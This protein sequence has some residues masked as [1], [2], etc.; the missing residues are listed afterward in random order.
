MGFRSAAT[1]PQALDLNGLLERLRA[2]P[3]R[4]LESEAA[5]KM[6]AR[7]KEVQSRLAA[8]S[9]SE[10]EATAKILL[11]SH[12]PSP[13][14]D[15]HFAAAYALDE[16]E[17]GICE[18]N[19][20]YFS[21][22]ALASLVAD[23]S[24]EEMLSSLTM[25]EWHVKHEVLVRRAWMHAHHKLITKNIRLELPFGCIVAA[26]GRDE[27]KDDKEF[28]TLIPFLHGLRAVTGK[29]LLLIEKC[30]RP[31]FR[32]TDASGV[33]FG[34][35]VS[36]VP[37]TKEGGDEQD[38]EEEVVNCLSI[39]EHEGIRVVI[40]EPP[41]WQ[42]IE[43]DMETLARWRDTE[44]L[45]A[46]HSGTRMSVCYPPGFC[47][48]VEPCSPAY[49]V[50]SSFKGGQEIE[51]NELAFGDSLYE[52]VRKKLWK[53]D[54]KAKLEPRVKPCYLALYA[55]APIRD[56]TRA[57]GRFQERFDLGLFLRGVADERRNGAA[58]HR[59]EQ[60]EPLS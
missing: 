49:T 52:S 19:D 25:Q 24:R 57:R 3:E 4:S 6:V 18:L 13:T 15:P 21:L 7:F 16:Y 34:V 47:V 60:S 39:L 44:L 22:L 50:I 29:Q 54:G 55:N 37:P 40:H 38:A 10:R 46:A 14:G 20:L 35:E 56:L 41:S 9:Y 17:H 51:Q 8:K 33:L 36:E 30:E 48:E 45:A 28:S 53:K 12:S 2:A 1:L 58:A 43:K 5:S 23:K 31:D 11:D 59:I 26:R 42:E 27:R 32:V